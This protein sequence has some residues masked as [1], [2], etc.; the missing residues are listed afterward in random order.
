[1]SAQ[2]CHLG[3]IGHTRNVTLLR[4]GIERPSAGAVA[5]ATR[6]LQI[7]GKIYNRASP[8]WVTS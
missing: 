3:R 4:I 5:A 8:E 7:E 6:R 1:M 2:R